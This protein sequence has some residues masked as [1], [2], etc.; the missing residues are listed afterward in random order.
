VAYELV[1]KSSAE[2]RGCAVGNMLLGILGIRAADLH[3]QYSEYR[4]Q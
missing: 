2:R 1:K 4:Q 3:Q